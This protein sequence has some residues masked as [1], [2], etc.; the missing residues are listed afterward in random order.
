MGGDAAPGIVIGGAEISCQRYPQLRFIIFGR[1]KEVM[2]LLEKTERL[3]SVANFVH[4]DDIVQ[5]D[6]KPA[7][8]L[9][10]GRKSSMRLAINAVQDGR[11]DGVCLCRQHRRIDGNVQVCFQNTARC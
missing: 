6:D 9:R 1:E 8:A 7:V 11:A 4:T 3:K 10:A 2:P 5:A